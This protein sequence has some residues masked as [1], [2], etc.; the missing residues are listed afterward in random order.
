[1]DQIASPG[2][3]DLATATIRAALEPM[4]DHLAQLMLGAGIVTLVGCVIAVAGWRRGS[5]H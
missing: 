3:R 2:A 1:M 5:A 4:T